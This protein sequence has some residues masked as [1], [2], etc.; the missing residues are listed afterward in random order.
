MKPQTAGLA[1]LARRNPLN[2]ENW[3]ALLEERR[4][5]I[6]PHLR[7]MSLKTLGDL[8]IVHDDVNRGAGNGRRL[9]VGAMVKT[10]WPT[11]ITIEYFQPGPFAGIEAGIYSLETRGIFADDEIFYNGHYHSEFVRSHANLPAS[12]HVLYFWGLT[13]DGVWISI[14]CVTRRFQCLRENRTEVTK[15][16]VTEASPLEICRLC[17]I[18]LRWLWERL[19]DATEAW[20]KHRKQLMEEAETLVTTVRQ[21]NTLLSIVEPKK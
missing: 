9:R 7:S 15:V 17:H 6:E 2:G 12:G 4:R 20:L 3:L 1:I 19:G 18:T 10:D 21:E 16:I 5:L 14:E 8:K 13:R 11:D